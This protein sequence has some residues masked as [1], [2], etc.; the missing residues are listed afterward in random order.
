MGC[1]EGKGGYKKD[2]GLRM[3]QMLSVKVR[4]RGGREK[5]EEGMFENEMWKLNIE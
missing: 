3:A 4:E 2:H 5:D 1:E